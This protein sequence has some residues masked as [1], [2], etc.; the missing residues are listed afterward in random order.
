MRVILVSGKI[1][2]FSGF[3]LI[4]LPVNTLATVD[5]FYLANL[6]LQK[7]RQP[8]S[9]PQCRDIIIRISNLCLVHMFSLGFPLFLR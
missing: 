5:G 4:V 7:P 2:V 9:E 8:S 3:L 6:G 1:L